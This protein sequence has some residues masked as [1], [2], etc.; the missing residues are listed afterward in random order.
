MLE[1]SFQGGNKKKEM[2]IIIFKQIFFILHFLKQNKLNDK[3]NIELV[4]YFFINSL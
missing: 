2:A 3:F 4:F 1:W